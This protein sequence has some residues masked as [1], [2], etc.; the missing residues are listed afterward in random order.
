MQWEKLPGNFLTLVP[1]Q[2]LLSTYIK[3]DHTRESRHRNCSSSQKS[4]GRV[5]VIEIVLEVLWNSISVML[6]DKLFKIRVSKSLTWWL[7][8]ELHTQQPKNTHCFQEYSSPAQKL[9]ITYPQS[10][11]EQIDI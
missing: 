4:Y 2:M 1:F 3:A 11:S 9:V 8:N 10:T 5:L 6:A 7:Y